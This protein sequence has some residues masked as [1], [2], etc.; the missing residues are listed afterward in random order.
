MNEI[1]SDNLSEKCLRRKG[2]VFMRYIIK[3]LFSESVDFTTQ[4]RIERQ[5][6]HQ[7]ATLGLRLLK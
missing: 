4:Y 5:P 2:I 3:I 6:S 1:L 7:C